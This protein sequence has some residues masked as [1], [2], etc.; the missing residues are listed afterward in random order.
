VYALR[1]S[2]GVLRWHFPT[3]EDVNGIVATESVVV[4]TGDEGAIWGLGLA[5]GAELWRVDTDANV[6]GNPVI[7]GDMVVAGDAAGT[8]WAVGLN[9]VVRWQAQLSGALRGGPASDGSVIYVVSDLGDLGA[10]S[11]DGFELWH[12]RI[13]FETNVGTALAVVYGPPT[14]VG[15][16]L[17]VTFTVDGGPGSPGVVAFDRY[18]G[19]LSWWGNDPDAV[20]EVRWANVRSSVAA[21]NDGLVLASSVSSGVQLLAAD[22]GRATWAGDSGIT[23]GRQWASPVVMGDLIIL[24]RPDGAVYGFDAGDG[25]LRWRMPAPS[26]ATA[27]SDCT[28]A[29]GIRF[30]DG[31][32]LEASAAVAPSGIVI[33]ASTGT[34]I[35]AIAG[36]R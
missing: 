22:T 27:V 12:E 20:S 33:V 32:A 28:S 35:F 18:V 23:C 17:V 29:D 16:Q 30:S 34:E 9:G 10:F 21:T 1:A 5:D 31:P 13:V 36:S 11:P 2:D 14:I 15:D 8:L 7:V 26:T 25:S 3:A 24:P 6:F 4:V 19:S